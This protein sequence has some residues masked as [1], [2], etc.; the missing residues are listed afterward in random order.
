MKGLHVRS[1]GNKSKNKYNY[2]LHSFT[3]NQI[4]INSI[5]ALLP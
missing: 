4:L 5:V 2:K 3:N 1:L